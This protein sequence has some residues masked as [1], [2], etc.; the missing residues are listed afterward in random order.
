M[1]K[2]REDRLMGM[3]TQLY[4]IINLYFGQSPLSWKKKL[5]KKNLSNINFKILGALFFFIINKKYTDFQKN[6]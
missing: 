5:P 4:P 3:M 1:D 6:P 2:M